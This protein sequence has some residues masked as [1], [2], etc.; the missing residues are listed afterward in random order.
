MPLTCPPQPRAPQHPSCA[1]SPP[2]VSCSL[3]SLPSLLAFCLAPTRRLSFPLSSCAPS[4]L[5]AIPSGGGGAPPPRRSVATTLHHHPH[6][7]FSPLS[8][9]VLLNLELGR[10][11]ATCQHRCCMFLASRRKSATP[12][13]P[14]SPPCRDESSGTQGGARRAPS[15]A[16]LVPGYKE[17]IP[18]PLLVRRGRRLLRPAPCQFVE[19][20]LGC[21]L[22]LWERS[23]RCAASVPAAGRHPTPRVAAVCTSP[24]PP[25]PARLVWRVWSRRGAGAPRAWP[26]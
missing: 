2:C 5:A 20:L 13:V 10:G 4:L 12:A 15:I 22:G 24:T 16:L 1:P 19:A 7:G 14:T 25:P 17:I 3:S 21:S 18:R 9:R 6:T 11:G 26:L 23:T 8:Q